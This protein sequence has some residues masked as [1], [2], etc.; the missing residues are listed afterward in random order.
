MDVWTNFRE[1]KLQPP[2]GLIRADAH[3]PPFRPDLKVHTCLAFSSL[4]LQVNSHAGLLVTSPRL[5][6][7][8]LAHHAVA[9]LLCL[10]ATLACTVVHYQFLQHADLPGQLFCPLLLFV[11][12]LCVTTLMPTRAHSPSSTAVLASAVTG[13]TGSRANKSQSSVVHNDFA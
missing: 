2:A 4:C 10:Q 5:H 3:R 12:C 9:C 1:Y 8:L 13:F 11:C 7:W 6:E